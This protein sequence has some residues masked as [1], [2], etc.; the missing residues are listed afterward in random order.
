[1]K[2][3]KRI[4]AGVLSAC[5]IIGA[6][7]CSSASKKKDGDFEVVASFYPMYIL[8]SNLTKG[9]DGVKLTNMTRPDVGCIHDYTLTT[10]DLEKIENADAFVENGMGLESFNDKIIKAYPKMKIIDSSKEIKIDYS[11]FT[12][13]GCTDEDDC[14]DD[15]EEGGQNGHIWTN[16]ELYVQ[17]IKNITDGLIE[18]DSK[19][20]DEYQKNS[21]EYINK[22]NDVISEYKKVANSLNGKKAVVLDETLQHFCEYNRMDYIYLETDHDN[23]SLGA[24]KIKDIVDNMKKNNIKSVFI[25]KTSDDKNAQTIAK[26]A[27]AK[28]YKLNSCMG[29]KVEKNAYIDD[30]KEN[31]KTLLSAE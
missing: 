17:Q 9:I 18:A 11:T 3:V 29:G 13:G 28:I 1:M 8:T 14:D 22:I 15:D 10:K 7:G 27:G 24:N 2:F 20:K 19:H 31:L 21:D 16:P 12:E 5:M 6:T 30:M 26:E 4:V 25:T 23:E